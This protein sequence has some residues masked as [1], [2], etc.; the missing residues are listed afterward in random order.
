MRFGIAK[1]NPHRGS[2][3]ESWLDEEGIRAEVVDAA[4]RA[5]IAHQLAAEMKKKCI[6]KKR[7]A[8]LMKTS[9][10]QVDRLLDP[11]D[12]SATI[13]TLQRAARI[14]GRDLRMELI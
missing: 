8:E 3:F 2:S 10:A 9:R 14:V 12:G 7:M 5:I 1:K 6:T 11:D 13:E 4:T